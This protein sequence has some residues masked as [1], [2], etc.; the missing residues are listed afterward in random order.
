[1]LLF[2]FGAILLVYRLYGK[3]GL[4]VWVPIAV[5]VANI[6]VLKNIELF[7]FTTTLGNIVYAS[8]F[9]VTDILSENYGK[10]DAKK[11]VFIGFISLAVVVFLMQLALLFTPAESDISQSALSTI[12]SLLPRIAGASFLAYLISQFHDIWAFHLWKRRFPSVRFLWLRN[13]A[14]TAVS[15]LI[16]TVV[17]TFVAFLGTYPFE[18]VIQILWTTYV[19]KLLVAGFDTPFVYIART[20]RGKVRAI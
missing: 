1:M 10:K 2:N 15:Q 4:Y 5:I 7:G 18:V 8:S 11:A 9:L 6:Q 13:T 20:W 3:T 19:I 17:F 16:D 12:F 14:S